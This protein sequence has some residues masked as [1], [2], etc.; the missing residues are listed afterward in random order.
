MLYIIFTVD[1]DP[2]IEFTRTDIKALSGGEEC[3]VTFKIIVS[4]CI[5]ITSYPAAILS[6]VHWEKL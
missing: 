6:D 3:R 1:L 5:I 4:T 2:D